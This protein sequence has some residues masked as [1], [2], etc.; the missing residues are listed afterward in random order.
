VT[1]DSSS[2]IRDTRDREMGIA[3]SSVSALLARPPARL[4]AS[5][6]RLSHLREFKGPTLAPFFPEPPR[7]DIDFSP[8]VLTTR[9]FASRRLKLSFPYFPS[10]RDARG[11][12]GVD[13]SKCDV[14]LSVY[15]RGPLVVLPCVPLYLGSRHFTN[16]SIESNSSQPLE[17]PKH[18]KCDGVPDPTVL[19]LSGSNDYPLS[20]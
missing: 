13:S 20:S 4:N 17:P 14:C 8:L 15:F 9:D 7:G 2:Q 11:Q 3:L 19:P 12:W 6:S 10:P 16:F 18:A 5:T 1:P